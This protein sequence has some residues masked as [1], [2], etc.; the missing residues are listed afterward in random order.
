MRTVAVRD[1]ARVTRFGLGEE[2]LYQQVYSGE[3]YAQIWD[4]LS[5]YRRRMMRALAKEGTN[6]PYASGFI[7]RN[8]LTSSSHAKR[9]LGALL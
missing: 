9:S 5:R 4:G 2:M 7:E 3:F 6:S 1:R 8:R